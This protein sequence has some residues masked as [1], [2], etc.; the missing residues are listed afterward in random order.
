[1]AA[2]KKNREPSLAD[3]IAASGETEVSNTEV[4]LRDDLADQRFL[5]REFL[6][7]LVYF[8]DEEGDGGQFAGQDAV[9]PFR[10]RIGERAVLRALGDATGEIA[11]RGPATGHSSD[12]R[13]AIAGGLTVR[14]LDLIFERDERLW[15]ATVSA[16]NFDLK[17][18]KLPELLSEE[19]SERVNERLTLIADLDGMLK[20]SFAVFLHDRLTS[21]WQKQ[22][23]P[24]LRDW[25]KRSILE[26]KYLGKE[27]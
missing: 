1:M 27:A 12:V 7:W 25:L 15:M 2:P 3:Q 22:T 6:T 24:A 19:D 8:C 23:I 5:G 17:R 13:Y 21:R 16:E 26:E 11:A 9:A 4:S 10:L 14:E 18:V 20:A